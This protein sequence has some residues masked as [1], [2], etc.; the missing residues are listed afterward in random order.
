MARRQNRN[1]LLVPDSRVGMAAFQADVLRK[2]GYAV[3]P[4]HPQ[5][6]KYQVAQ[7][8]GVP[9]QPGYNGQLDTESAGKVGGAIGGLMVRELVR[10]AQQQLTQQHTHQQQGDQSGGALQ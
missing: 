5:A 10:M 1:R 2:E 9:L 7:S 8:L 3:D 6:A 4:A